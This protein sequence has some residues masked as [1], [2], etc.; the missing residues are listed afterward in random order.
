MTEL[1]KNLTRVSTAT[2]E[3]GRK[4]VLTLNAENQ[5][6][7]LKPKGRTAKAE[8]KHGYQET[9]YNHEERT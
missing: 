6:I 7:S 5:S 3:D 9:L 8:S 2:D 1:T 4:L